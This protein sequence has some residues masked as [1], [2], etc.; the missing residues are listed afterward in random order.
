[1]K[2]DCIFTTPLTKPRELS[3]IVPRALSEILDVATILCFPSTSKFASLNQLYIPIQGNFL[4]LLV[5]EIV[6]LWPAC[7]IFLAFGNSFF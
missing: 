6:S 5:L 7:I 2:R 1:M 4:L 3:Y